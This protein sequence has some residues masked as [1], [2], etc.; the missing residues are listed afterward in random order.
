MIFSESTASERYS[1]SGKFGACRA[2]AIKRFPVPAS[3]GL[4]E[5]LLS[6]TCSQAKA[7]PAAAPGGN[8]VE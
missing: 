8:T 6:A 5:G 4:A 2:P 7:N 3:V 1:A